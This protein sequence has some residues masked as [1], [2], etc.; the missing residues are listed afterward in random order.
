MSM[1]EQRIQQQFFESADLKYQS[2]EGLARDVA[3]ATTAL[4]GAITAGGKVLVCGSGAGQALAGHLQALL[5][6][7]FERE[8]PPLAAIEI[9]TAGALATQ[10][11]SAD[12]AAQ[13]MRALAQPG[14]V[15]VVVDGGGS[16]AATVAAVAAARE[17][18]ASVVVLSNSA[19][20]A[21]GER[22]SETDVWISVPHER[23][24]RVLEMHL[25]VLHAIC[26][27]LDLQLL[28]EQ[29]SS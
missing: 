1:L 13:Q 27:A 4:L 22:L 16:D 17:Q 25:L 23:A 3:A 24:A 21:W 28:G 18:D 29:E 20:T 5:I 14:D 15:L 2:A 8:R 26:D 12:A 11:G 6:G 9:N 10:L 19:T 7:H